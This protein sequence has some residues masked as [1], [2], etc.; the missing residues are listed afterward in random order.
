MHRRLPSNSRLY[1]FITWWW[2][3]V[4][5]GTGLRGRPKECRSHLL[6]YENP[7][8]TASYI[9][10]SDGSQGYTQD[11]W[12]DFMHF[13][14]THY[15]CTVS[16][17][18]FYVFISNT[19]PTMCSAYLVSLDVIT[20]IIFSDEWIFW[21]SSLCISVYVPHIRS[22]GIFQCSGISFGD[23]KYI[24]QLYCSLKHQFCRY[25]VPMWQLILTVM[26]TSARRQDVAKT[27]LLLHSSPN[28]LTLQSV[29]LPPF[30]Q[31]NFISR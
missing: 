14:V 11:W 6:N 23:V 16:S 3:L 9:V 5:R 12:N 30:L 2:W 15:K 20:R 4:A 28:A 8:W 22:S 19:I 13:V 27:I 1:F 10:C 17:E 7:T 25:S 31:I 24:Y 29:M 21:N 18:G 26:N